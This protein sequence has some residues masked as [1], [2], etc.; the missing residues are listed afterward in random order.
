M[1]T[2]VSH[3]PKNNNKDICK[4]K[5]KASD[6]PN[7]YPYQM[8]C[9][10]SSHNY[11]TFTSKPMTHMTRYIQ[12]KLENYHIYPVKA[13]CTKWSFTMSTAT[14]SGSNQPR[15]KPGEHILACEQ[16]LQCMKT[17]EIIPTQQVLDNKISSTNKKAITDSGM[18]YKLFPSNNHWQNIAKKAIK[19]WKDHFLLSSA[20]QT[21]NFP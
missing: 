2:N 14:P 10:H 9:L 19:S 13:I 5:D 15:T 12:T 21:T 7:E 18:S 20:E 3:N 1:S 16:A 8:S 17:C 11:E 4:A 6:P